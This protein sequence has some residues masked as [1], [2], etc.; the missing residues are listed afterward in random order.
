VG[1]R[2][3]IEDLHTEDITR[4][5]GFHSDRTRKT[6]V[7]IPVK[8]IGVICHVVVAYQTTCEVVAFNMEH[9][10]WC[11]RGG[12]RYVWVPSV[13]NSILALQWLI[14]INRDYWSH[15]VVR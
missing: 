3:D 9:L 10:V 13:M 15:S 1:K 2:L 7:P 4:L 5:S 14:Y 11:N 8:R 12:S 6:V